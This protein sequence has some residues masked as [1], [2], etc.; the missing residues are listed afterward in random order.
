MDGLFLFI[1]MSLLWQTI[2]ALFTVEVE[3]GSYQAQYQGNVT[4]GCMF[5][6]G[7]G[8][9]TVVWQRVSPGKNLE[10]YRL[11]HGKEDLETQ[12]PSFSGRTR[13]VMED[14]ASGWARLEITHL[15]INDSGTYQCLLEMGGADYKQTELSV[16]ASYKAII[17]TLERSTMGGE[18]ELG[19]QSVGYP[20]ASVTWMDGTFQELPSNVTSVR[21]P[22]QL[23]QVTS[24]LKVQS[25][26]MNNYTCVFEERNM[27]NTRSARFI[28]PDDIQDHPRNSNTPII[29]I[30][31]LVVAGLIITIILYYS[32]QK[33]SRRDTKHIF[34]TAEEGTSV[35]TM[36]VKPMENL[37]KVLRTNCT[38]SSTN[39][40]AREHLAVFCEKACCGTPQQSS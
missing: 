15:G 31:C 33:G 21:T 26:V 7:T 39:E 24:K 14:L 2:S 13:L 22:E 18:L 23:F 8:D 37:R 34:V 17:Q 10:V 12:D 6:P 16:K 35:A 32:R 3:Q 30:P 28:I 27:Q 20:L 36:G 5:Q 38:E 9:L 40:E 1:L 29:V 25:S 19:C 11:E 4:M